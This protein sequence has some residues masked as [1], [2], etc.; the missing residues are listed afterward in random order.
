LTKPTCEAL[1]GK[2][3][4]AGHVRFFNGSKLPPTT[5]FPANV[6]GV[7]QLSK[8]ACGAP[9]ETTSQ[10]AVPPP[11]FLKPVVPA[12]KMEF[13]ITM[14][15]SWGGNAAVVPPSE[16]SPVAEPEITSVMWLIVTFWSTS[17]GGGTFVFVPPKM[18]FVYTLP[19]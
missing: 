1:V 13:S 7:Q 3:V 6:Y 9:E 5:T 16:K 11:G 15:L 8:I 14:L 4:E 19:H 12:L 17:L 2:N 10:F 18:A